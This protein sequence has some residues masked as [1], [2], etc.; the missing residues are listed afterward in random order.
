MALAEVEELSASK[1][2]PTYANGEVPAVKLGRSLT[3]RLDNIKSQ[4]Q[5]ELV[6]LTQ[7]RDAL[8][9]EIS[10][11]KATRDMFLEETT[12][13]NARNE[14]LAQLGAQYTRRMET[15]NAPPVYRHEAHPP[16][17][18]RKSSSF[19]NGRT[20][21]PGPP[22]GIQASFSTSTTSS[23][24]L[25]D[26]SHGTFSRSHKNL[27]EMTSP[28]SRPGK[29]K[30]KG[31]KEKNPSIAVAADHKAPGRREH[32][33]QQ[34]SVL[35]FTRCDHCGDKM[36]GSQLRCSGKHD[37][38]VKVRMTLTFISISRLQHIC[39]C[40]VYQPCSS[41]LFTQSSI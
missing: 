16:P 3:M 41:H 1:S 21:Q 35:R 37:F 40:P 26:E 4:Y 27:S 36:W 31:S 19:D 14:E 12:V 9:R 15:S 10:D 30:W 17:L 6:P 34:L 24:A 28:A 39:T 32:T 22:P 11:L 25:S 23:A 7:Q 8:M 13:L 18:E 38:D 20:Q 5:H 33:F 29:F 2:S